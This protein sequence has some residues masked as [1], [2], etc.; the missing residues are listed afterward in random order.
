[1]QA[2]QNDK[3]R[4]TGHPIPSVRAMTSSQVPAW[5]EG[6]G[7]KTAA[8]NPSP[9]RHHHSHRHTLYSKAH[10]VSPRSA[11]LRVNVGNCSPAAQREKEE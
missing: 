6:A 4:H 10:R 5:H 2:K 11:F 7:H 9:E 1:M 8:G 3:D